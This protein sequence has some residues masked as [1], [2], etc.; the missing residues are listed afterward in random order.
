ML[1]HKATQTDG[2]VCRNVPKKYMH[3]WQ[4]DSSLWCYELL[5]YSS[6]LRLY[7]IK[8]H[9]QPSFWHRA[10]RGLSL[11]CSRGDK[12]LHHTNKITFALNFTEGT[13][14][15]AE[16][17]FSSQAIW[18]LPASLPM[19]LTPF[20]LFP[21]PTALGKTGPIVLLLIPVAKQVHWRGFP[22]SLQAALCST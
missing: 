5:I 12:A 3:F 2:W 15:L 17:V 13:Q 7:L 4:C 21:N 16:V 22:A 9:H 1:G 14:D 18:L 8:K 10:E 6:I 11:D 19:T 20:C